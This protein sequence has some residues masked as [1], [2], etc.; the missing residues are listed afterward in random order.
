MQQ[1]THEELVCLQRLER[2]PDTQ[3]LCSQLVLESLLTKGLIEQRPLLN[4]PV[5]PQ[6]SGYHLTSAGI[7]VVRAAREL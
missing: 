5:I 1:I 6:Q 4:L 7:K 3:W 2:E